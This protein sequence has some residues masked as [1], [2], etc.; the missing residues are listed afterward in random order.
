MEIKRRDAFI[1]I[2]KGIGIVSIVIGHSSWLLPKTQ[3]PIG[4]FVYTYHIMLFFFVAG[5]C[6]K[7]KIDVTPFQLIGKRL[8]KLVPLYIKYSVLFIIL[9]NL[10]KKMY[11]LSMDNVIYEKTDMINHILN[12]CVLVGS[13]QLLGA[14][15][16][17]P[18]F[19]VGVSFFYCFFHSAEK[20]RYSIVIH[21]GCAAF[22]A[23]IGVWLNYK[24][25]NLQYH[26]QTSML[27]ISIIYLGYLFQAYR[28]KIMKYLRW[29][30]T[31]IWG[32]CIW[33]IVTLNIGII[34]LSANQIIHP[35]IFYP[36]TIIG[37]LFC[38]CMAQGIEKI[39]I[40]KNLFSVLGKN[41][42]H[43]MALHFLVFKV[44]DLCYGKL[45][46]ADIETIS[47]YPYAFGNLWPIYYICGAA[48]PVLIIYIL[49][50][51]LYLSNPK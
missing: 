22:S 25:L 23:M 19:M 2:L 15:W 35:L 42:Y 36:V 24:Q 9:H 6:F 48:V 37:I 38:I 51:G 8:E 45:I 26:I 16:F 40:L 39:N 46:C 30:M 41:S 13:E 50:K 47:K 32:I 34:E 31:G 29:W 18:M 1:D 44:I 20:F 49:K 10:F 33:K 11:M 12:A 5:M 17:I 3:F 4:P 7:Y 28:I 27:G 43:T 21:I 14:F